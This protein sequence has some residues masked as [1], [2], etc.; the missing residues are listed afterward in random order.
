ME[1]FRTVCKANM[2]KTRYGRF[3][4]YSTGGIIALGFLY[5]PYS[6][7]EWYTKGF[8][9]ETVCWNS[10]RTYMRSLIYMDEY[11]ESGRI[12]LYL[13]YKECIHDSRYPK[14]KKN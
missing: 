12:D 5:Y 4:V 1:V 10:Y 3:L 7:Y 8:Y 6:I 9:R 11:T 2:P 13:N 14:D